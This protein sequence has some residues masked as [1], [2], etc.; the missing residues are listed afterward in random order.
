[1]TRAEVKKQIDAGWLTTTVSMRLMGLDLDISRFRMMVKVGRLTAVKDN[2]G[3]QLFK[4]EDVLEHSIWYDKSAKQLLDKFFPISRRKKPVTEQ[5]TSILHSQTDHEEFNR[6]WFRLHRH[7]ST[8]IASP[9]QDFRFGELKLF[10]Q[11]MEWSRRLS[12]FEL[13]ITGEQIEEATGLDD[14]AWPKMRRSLEAR[15]ILMA[16]RNGSL[17]WV[18]RFLD[19]L[20]KSPF[21]SLADNALVMFPHD[22]W[23]DLTD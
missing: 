5:R 11:L 20:T 3:E 17:G 14:E 4:L 2:T 23:V 13:V 9:D 7:V 1:M 12:T 10:H 18:L 22:S 8:L 21:E 19:P 16:E 6:R 15:S